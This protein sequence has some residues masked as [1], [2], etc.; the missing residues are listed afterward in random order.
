MG[1]LQHFHFSVK[2]LM[3]SRKMG[4]SVI[5]KGVL[6]LLIFWHSKMSSEHSKE[7]LSWLANNAMG[8][9]TPQHEL[10]PSWEKLKPLVLKP[11]VLKKLER[12]VSE[13][14][15]F[16]GSSSKIRLRLRSWILPLLKMHARSSIALDEH[17]TSNVSNINRVYRAHTLHGSFEYP[18]ANTAQLKNPVIASEGWEGLP[19]S[20][21]RTLS[22]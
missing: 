11:I 19:R 10:C 14:K 17:S 7:S 5:D 20:N 15:A 12:L 6:F 9:Q 22:P 16:I 18:P 21:K 4:V 8:W 3:Y 1:Q 2:V 13:V